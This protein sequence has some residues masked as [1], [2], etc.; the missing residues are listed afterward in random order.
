MVRLIQLKYAINIHLTTLDV[1][2]NPKKQNKK[3]R[4][5]IVISE[6]IKFKMQC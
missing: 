4:R 3:L 6:N 1:T 5:N 2:Y